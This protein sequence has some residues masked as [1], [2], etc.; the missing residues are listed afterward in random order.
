MF[1][2]YDTVHVPFKNLLEPDYQEEGLS[3]SGD[4]ENYENS[5]HQQ[6]FQVNIKDLQ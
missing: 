3:L 6:I 5:H 4:H 1:G 2:Q